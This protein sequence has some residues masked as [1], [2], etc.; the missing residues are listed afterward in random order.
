MNV[1]TL[2][3]SLFVLLFA[4]TIHE[5]AHGWAASKLGDETA[6]SMGRVTLNPIAH[7]DPFGT[8]LLPLLLVLMKAPPFGWAKPVPVNPFNLRNPRRDNLWISAAGPMANILAA[9]LSL[10]AIILVKLASPDVSV[11]LKNFLMGRGGLPSGF[12]PLEGLVIILFYGVLVNTYLV[13]FNLIPVPPLDG[14]GVLMG[15][16]S[17]G[18]AQ[19]YDRLRPYGFLI[20]I[21]LIYMGVLSFI[22]RPIEILIYTL[23]FL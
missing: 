21:G 14:S 20:V 19:K 13:V 23:I 16:L 17:E 10:L 1:I 22:I 7:I 12:H 9:V 5:A 11:F 2:V 15:L 18:A 8:V 3:I 6:R 4:I